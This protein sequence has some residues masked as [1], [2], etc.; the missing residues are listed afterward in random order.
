LR[1]P[2]FSPLFPSLPLSL[3]D[4]VLAFLGAVCLDIGAHWAQMYASLLSRAS[5]HKDVST[6]TSPLLRAYY[7][8]RLFMG[9]L[10]VGAEVFYMVRRASDGALP[11]GS[12]GTRT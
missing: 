8:H 2:L 11:T 5:S 9:S 10:C 7:T 3:Q 4:Y 12:I 1:L 6:T